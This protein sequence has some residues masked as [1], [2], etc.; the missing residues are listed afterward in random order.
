MES[1]YYAE[2]GECFLHICDF[3]SAIL[4]YKKACILLPDNDNYYSRLAVIYYFQGQCFF[5]SKLYSDALEAFSRATEM[6]ADIVG[7]HIKRYIKYR[8]RLH[9]SKQGFLLAYADKLLIANKKSSLDAVRHYSIHHS[10]HV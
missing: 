5:D 1:K 6:K 4:N 3:Q 7:Y 8:A 9:Y 2:R 10:S